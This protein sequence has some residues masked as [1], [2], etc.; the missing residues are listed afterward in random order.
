[1]G[2]FGKKS[3]K[4]MYL[5]PNAAVVDARSKPPDNGNRT[6]GSNAVTEIGIASVIH[7]TAIHKVVANTAF[8]AVLSPSG[9]KNISTPTKSNGPNS[10][11]ICLVLS[12]I[13]RDMVLLIMP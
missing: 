8:P 1:M 12:R 5:C 6:I 11:P 4:K 7:Q 9:W 3:G 13:Q 10:M 2:G